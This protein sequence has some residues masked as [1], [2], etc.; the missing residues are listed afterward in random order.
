MPLVIIRQ[1][2]IKRGDT[3][4]EPVQALIDSAAGT[5]GRF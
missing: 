5:T 4:A 3:D 1:A 2:D